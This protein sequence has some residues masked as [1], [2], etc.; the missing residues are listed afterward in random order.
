MNRRFRQN[1]PWMGAGNAFVKSLDLIRL[2]EMAAARHNGVS[3]VDVVEEFGVNQRT[4][5][6]MIRGL[7]MAF[8][9]LA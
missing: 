5:Q 9:G 4:A 6:R 8:P 2:A 7:E 3:L 1:Q